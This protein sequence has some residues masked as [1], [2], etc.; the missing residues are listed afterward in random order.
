M[1]MLPGLL[2]QMNET[3]YGSYG[4]VMLSKEVFFGGVGIVCSRSVVQKYFSK[5]ACYFINYV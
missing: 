2:F 3:Q 1:R 4:N 5:P